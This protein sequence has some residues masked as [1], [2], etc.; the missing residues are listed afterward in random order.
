MQQAIS[1]F[2]SS[3]DKVEHLG[4]LRQ[5]LNALTAPVLDTSDILRSQIVL[6]VSALDYYIHEITVLGMID[7]YERRRPPTDAFLK[8]RIP[9]SSWASTGTIPSGSSWFASEVRERHGFLSFQQPDKIADAIRLISTVRLWRAVAAHLSADEESVKNRLRLIVERRNKIAH[10]ADIDPSY[11]GQRWP[12]LENDVN[13]AISFL[14]SL[15][16]AIHAV[17]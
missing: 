14:R 9:V 12:I 5:A 8:F 6:S 10:E 4:G 13:G 7:I 17:V 1:T 3:L 11:P 2:H 16:D 15:G